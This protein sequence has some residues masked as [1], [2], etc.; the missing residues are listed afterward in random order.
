MIIHEYYPASEPD[1][2]ILLIELIGPDERKW[3]IRAL[4]DRFGDDM[5]DSEAGRKIL[6]NIL[7]ENN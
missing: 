3:F 6:K 7:T 4:K 2:V 1:N 5:F